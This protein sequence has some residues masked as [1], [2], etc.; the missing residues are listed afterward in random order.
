MK[1]RRRF[2]RCLFTPALLTLCGVATAQT[3]ISSGRPLANASSVLECLYGWPI[4]YEDTPYVYDGDIE[5]AT[6]RV[7]KDGKSARDG[8][9][10]ILLPRVRTFSFT[11]EDVARPAR[12]ARSPEA[13]ARAAILAM[14]KSYSDSV[15]GAEMFTL[16]ES[17]GLFHVVPVQRR[18][19][20]GRL[21]KVAPLLDTPVTLPAKERSGT[22]L[23]L[24]I[25]QFLTRQ[26][27][28]SVGMG[29]GWRSNRTYVAPR[30]G[31]PARSDLSRLLAEQ[32]A[33]LPYSWKLFYQPGSGYGLNIE[34]VDTSRQPTTY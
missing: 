33:P 28:E 7:R 19:K 32:A 2:I 15:G 5:D 11:L 23:L 24:D 26:T 17:N 31:E 25:C 29:H 21:E 13:P 4:T 6:S 1:T 14:L 10:Q 12:G 34:L 18:D 9:P 8:V 30:P 3:V 20:S 22:Q 16:T 27:G